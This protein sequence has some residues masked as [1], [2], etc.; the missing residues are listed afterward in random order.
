ML[1]YW[2]GWLV[3]WFRTK[4]GSVPGCATRTSVA[5]FVGEQPWTSAPRCCYPRS[6]WSMMSSI[7]SETY[8]LPRKRF[9]L[10]QINQRYAHMSHL[11]HTHLCHTIIAEFELK[12]CCFS[13]CIALIVFFQPEIL[14][15]LDKL[16]LDMVDSS[17]PTPPALKSPPTPKSPGSPFSIIDW[18]NLQLPPLRL[19]ESPTRD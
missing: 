9:P 7:F 15:D 10:V 2:P 17:P 3:F 12:F 5:P 11:C 1:S 14:L 18:K 4:G 6:K 19:K 16:E 8:Y 13:S